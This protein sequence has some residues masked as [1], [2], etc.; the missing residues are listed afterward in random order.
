MT[1]DGWQHPEGREHWWLGDQ[2]HLAALAFNSGADTI[3]YGI[4]WYSNG[5]AKGIQC[6]ERR[7]TDASLSAKNGQIVHRTSLKP[8]SNK[9]DDWCAA[10]TTL[11]TTRHARH[12][13]GV[14]LF[15]FGKHHILH[16]RPSLLSFPIW[17]F[18]FLLDCGITVLWLGHI[19]PLQPHRMEWL[20]YFWC[21]AL[22]EL[23]LPSLR[24][25][26]LVPSLLA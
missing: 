5:G 25:A 22:L 18:F 7:R 6:W 17:S 12:L 1:G 20:A 26:L 24:L 13:E 11:D 9:R 16:L 2:M 3:W 21:L 15:L 23:L 4:S 8:W 10:V 14:Q 19:R